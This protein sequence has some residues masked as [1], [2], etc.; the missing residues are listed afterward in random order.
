MQQQKEMPPKFYK[1]P[2]SNLQIADNSYF[3]QMIQSLEKEIKVHYSFYETGITL[4]LKLAKNSI[5]KKSL[6]NLTN[7]IDIKIL[8]KI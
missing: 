6:P 2:L 5:G 8:N 7:D 4:I 1:P 3:I